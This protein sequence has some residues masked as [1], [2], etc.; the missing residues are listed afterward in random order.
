MKTEY[1]ARLV[2]IVLSLGLTIT[3][4]VISVFIVSPQRNTAE[5]APVLEEKVSDK[6]LFSVSFNLDD[7]D[8]DVQSDSLSE[9]AIWVHPLLSEVK[10]SDGKQIRSVVEITSAAWK[11][12]P[13][14]HEIT[15]PGI[16]ALPETAT[17]HGSVWHVYY[18]DRSKT[19]LVENSHKYELPLYSCRGGVSAE[20]SALDGHVIRLTSDEFQ[21][22]GTQDVLTANV[23]PLLPVLPDFAITTCFEEVSFAQHLEL[24][25]GYYPGY[26]GNCLGASSEVDDAVLAARSKELFAQAAPTNADDFSKLAQSLR[27]VLQECGYLDEN[28]KADL[29][30]FYTDGTI[31]LHY[32]PTSAN[33]YSAFLDL[34]CSVED[35]RPIAIR[36]V[37]PKPIYYDA[38]CL[39]LPT[40][41]DVDIIAW[42]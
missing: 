25:D 12:A 24:M 21:I 5:A 29:Q 27:D 2:T 13:Y 39:Q 34:Y 37:K 16:D 26:S 40:Y 7:S 32:V 20:I 36:L 14:L 30:A 3:A 19:D 31:R 28:W 23:E 10:L 1:K 8:T 9:R 18:Y 22:Q 35:G 4:I 38:G 17:L 42:N 33:A 6:R 15:T 41:G 11:L